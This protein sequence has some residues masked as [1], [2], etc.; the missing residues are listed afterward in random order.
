MR[1]AAAETVRAKAR[2]KKVAKV[3]RL[4]GR[5]ERAK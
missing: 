3:K 5:Q 1:K 4:L 2:K